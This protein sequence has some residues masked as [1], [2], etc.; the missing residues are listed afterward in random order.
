MLYFFFREKFVEEV[1]TVSDF[2]ILFQDLSDIDEYRKNGVFAS[3]VR[4]I[5]VDAC[6]NILCIPIVVISSIDSMALTL[7]RP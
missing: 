3:G 1:N 4:D 7:H 5:I 6:A 2:R